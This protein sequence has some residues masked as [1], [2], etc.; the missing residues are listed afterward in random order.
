MDH[1][2]ID[3]DGLIKPIIAAYEAGG[4]LREIPATRRVH[5]LILPCGTE[6]DRVNGIRW[7]SVPRKNRDTI[8]KLLTQIKEI[9][10]E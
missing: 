2:E 6:W 5:S 10:D 9:E 3:A 1:I 7:T 8:L 4:L